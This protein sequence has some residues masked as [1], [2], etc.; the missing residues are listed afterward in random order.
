MANGTDT[1]ECPV[2][3]GPM[4]WKYLETPVCYACRP[5]KKPE[6][7]FRLKVCDGKYEYVRQPDFRAHVYRHG[8]EWR[9]VTGD[10]F[11]LALVQRIEELEEAAG[12]LAA[13]MPSGDLLRHH[14]A[15]NETIELRRVLEEN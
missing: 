15:G 7:T 13:K 12:A 6:A 10:G 8:E 1:H 5:E 11:I 3:R 2:C 4:A 14:H 9:D